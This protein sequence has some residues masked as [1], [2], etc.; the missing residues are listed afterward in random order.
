MNPMIRATMIGWISTAFLASCDGGENDTTAVAHDF[1]AASLSRT[2]EGLPYGGKTLPVDRTDLT[3]QV[4]RRDSDMGEADL[5]IAPARSSVPG[6]QVARADNAVSIS[7]AHA[8]IR[9]FG[10]PVDTSKAIFMGVYGH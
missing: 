4:D 2:D 6:T 8:P 7:A 9:L 5:P 3:G 10:L 1:R